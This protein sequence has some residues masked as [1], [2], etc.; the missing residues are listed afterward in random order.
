MDSDMVNFWE[1]RL[2]ED[3]TGRVHRKGKTEGSDGGESEIGQE[4]GDARGRRVIAW[5]RSSK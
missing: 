2:G 5:G 1:V 4:F 3:T